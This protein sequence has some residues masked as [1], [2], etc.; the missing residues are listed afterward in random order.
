MQNIPL[1]WIYTFIL[2]WTRSVGCTEYVNVI[3]LNFYSFNNSER[4]VIANCDWLK[5]ARLLPTQPRRPGRGKRFFIEKKESLLTAGITPRPLTSFN[6][7]FLF[8]LL[9]PCP[10]FVSGISTSQEPLQGTSQVHFASSEGHVWWVCV[11]LTCGYELLQVWNMATTETQLML[12]VGLIGEFQFAWHLLLLGATHSLDNHM[13]PMWPESVSSAR[14]RVPQWSIT[15]ACLDCMSP[16]SYDTA[17]L[18]GNS[19]LK[20]ILMF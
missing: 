3:Q 16:P 7:L 6:T 1:F 15:A 5:T 14:L 19:K 4:T 18:P 10:A 17:L 12:S 13:T 20:Y 9:K 2:Y 8:C 11:Q